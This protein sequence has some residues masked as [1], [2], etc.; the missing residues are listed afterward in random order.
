MTQAP[1]RPELEDAGPV[2]STVPPLGETIEPL[3][4]TELPGPRALEHIA[5]DEQYTSPSLP[6]AYGIVPVRGEGA[7]IEDIDGNRFLD[8]CAGIAGARGRRRPLALAEGGRAPRRR[9]VT[10]STIVW[11]CSRRNCAT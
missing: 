9:A 4:R 10:Q 5:F 3:V 1:A 6:R 7:I 11:L 2:E 8:F